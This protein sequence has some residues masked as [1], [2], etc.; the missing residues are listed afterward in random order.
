MTQ[1]FKTY[2]ERLLD[3]SIFKGIYAILRE[4][5]DTCKDDNGVALVKECSKARRQLL[6]CVPGSSCQNKARCCLQN[7]LRWRPDF[8]NQKCKLEQVC[9]AAGVHFLMLPKC[10]PECNPIERYW[11]YTKRHCRQW[12]DYTVAGLNRVLPTA[13][14]SVPLDW[15]RK[16]F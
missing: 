3:R 2:V 4:G 12:C 15:V 7:F 16:S 1:V 8:A 9:E 6:G 10:H 14:L 5:G 13:F 11:N